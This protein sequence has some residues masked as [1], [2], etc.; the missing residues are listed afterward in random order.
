[1]DLSNTFCDTVMQLYQYNE[2]KASFGSIC[3]AWYFELLRPS[4]DVGLVWFC[5]YCYF[6]KGMI[7][8]SF[9]VGLRHW[10]SKVHNYLLIFCRSSAPTLG[11]VEQL[12]LGSLGKL[13][14]LKCLWENTQHICT[15]L[16]LQV[17]SNSSTGSSCTGG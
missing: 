17:A 4:Y 13:S 10:S 6:K 1:M 15:E 8:K 12:L 3:Y 14:L 5:W 7:S 2:D 9:T 16:A 11:Q